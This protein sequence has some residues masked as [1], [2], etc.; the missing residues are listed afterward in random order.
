MN[1]QHSSF[2]VSNVGI[3]GERTTEQA[4]TNPILF[5]LE[6]PSVP[7]TDNDPE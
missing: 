4:S 7:I 1:H 2:A 6:A 3:L 5:N